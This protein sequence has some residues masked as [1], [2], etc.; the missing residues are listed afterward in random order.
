VLQQ[1]KWYSGMAPDFTLP[2]DSC[3]TCIT[4]AVGGNCTSSAKAICGGDVVGSSSGIRA[5]DFA[6]HLLLFLLSLVQAT[7]VFLK[8]NLQLQLI[9]PYTTSASLGCITR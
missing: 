1:R 7:L 9:E 4:E 6:L 3:V 2:S 5:D 8:D